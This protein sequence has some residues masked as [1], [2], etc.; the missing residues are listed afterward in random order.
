MPLGQG[1]G[2]QLLIHP[3][4]QAQ[5]LAD[6]AAAGIDAILHQA[7]ALDAVRG[8]LQFLSGGLAAGIL[9]QGAGQRQ[10]DV[11]FR[12][13]NSIRKKRINSGNAA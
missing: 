6:G 5:L 1:S 12:Y 13:H 7:H 2:G 3:H 11:Q 9:A 10:V 8:N 4:E